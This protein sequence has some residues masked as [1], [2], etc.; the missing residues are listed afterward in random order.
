MWNLRTAQLFLTFIYGFLER[1]A[2]IPVG[3]EPG[4]PNLNSLR[5]TE[6]FS[7]YSRC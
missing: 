2:W 1:S 7:L 3:Q 6:W 5:R 4:A